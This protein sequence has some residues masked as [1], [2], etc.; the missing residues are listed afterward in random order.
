[1]ATNTNSNIFIQMAKSNQDQL[2]IIDFV[3]PLNC[4]FEI[5][6]FDETKNNYVFM[7]ER[8]INVQAG[9]LHDE[10]KL[11]LSQLTLQ[12]R[13]YRLA[14]TAEDGQHIKFRSITSITLNYDGTVNENNERHLNTVLFEI[15]DRR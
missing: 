6:G 12:R 8:K 3:Y 2:G 10:L 14:A 15:D 5:S 4:V 7:Y 1:M 9:T 11:H 13:S